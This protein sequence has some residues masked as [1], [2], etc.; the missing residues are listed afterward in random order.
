M[1]KEFCPYEQALE[2]KELGFDEPCFGKWLSSLQSN[3]K[4]YQL[5]LEMGMNEEFEDNR[6]VYLLEGACSALTFSQAFKWFREKYGWQHS[7]DATSDQHSFELG[8]NYWIWNYKTGE[9]YHTM[10]KNRPSGDWEYKTYEEAELACLKKLIE[11][12]K[13]K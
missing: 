11:I 7:I 1:N 13:T 4:V 3:W 8:Y 5:I 9:E 2:L 12:L 10:P 6:N